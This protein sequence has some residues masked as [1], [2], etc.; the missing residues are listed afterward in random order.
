MLYMAHLSRNSTSSVDFKQHIVQNSSKSHILHRI[1]PTETKFLRQ[2]AVVIIENNK[3]S[4]ACNDIKQTLCE[5]CHD[6]RLISS[7]SWKS[8]KHQHKLSTLCETVM[9]DVQ[10]TD[11][12]FHL[13]VRW[14]PIPY[15]S[16]RNVRFVENSV[17]FSLFCVAECPLLVP[18]K[19]NVDSTILP[20]KTTLKHY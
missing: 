9:A 2:N 18:N 8:S 16:L 5:V 15:Q 20:H 19:T 11:A 7:E 14:A 1:H 17:K 13:T 6:T 12:Y 4:I 10:Q 3:W